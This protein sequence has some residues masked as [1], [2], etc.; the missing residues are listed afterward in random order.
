MLDLP[1]MLT[2]RQVADIL[3]V[4]ERYVRADLIGKGRIRAIKLIDGGCWRIDA[5]SVARL[6]GRSVTV[7]EKS[8]EYYSQK[9]ALARGERG[10]VPRS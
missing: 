6:V 2:V 7:T 4:S 5:E 9:T 8:E 1:Q 3:Q 10:F